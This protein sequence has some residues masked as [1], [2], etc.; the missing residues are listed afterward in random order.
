LCL[1]QASLAELEAV[2]SAEAVDGLSVP[3][4]KTGLPEATPPI[5]GAVPPTNEQ[6]IDIEEASLTATA[7]T[8]A[9]S[10]VLR[11][12]PSSR[13]LPGGDGGGVVADAI[14]YCD[15]PCNLRVV[16]RFCQKKSQI[17][18]RQAF[19]QTTRKMKTAV[20]WAEPTAW[21]WIS[22]AGPKMSKW[23]AA[24]A[25]PAQNYRTS[26]RRRSTDESTLLGEGSEFGHIS[27]FY[28]HIENICSSPVQRPVEIEPRESSGLQRAFYKAAT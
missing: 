6:K 23:A 19:S 15:F 25:G 24:A 14:V 11:R 22:S 4:E 26:A 21:G 17:S 18:S 3:N 9:S 12:R 20:A 1:D 7:G 28:R 16:R 13:R 27:K 2:A 8:V 5:L 10:G